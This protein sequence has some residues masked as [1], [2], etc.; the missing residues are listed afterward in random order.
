MIKPSIKKFKCPNCG[1]NKLNIISMIEAER[2]LFEPVFKN[3]YLTYSRVG[4]SLLDWVDSLGYSYTYCCYNCKER[5]YDEDSLIRSGAF[6]K[7]MASELHALLD[8]DRTKS[9]ADEEGRDF[10]ITLH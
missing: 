10:E 1:S 3:G 9:L 4:S 7:I 5:W 8:R 6:G 2:R